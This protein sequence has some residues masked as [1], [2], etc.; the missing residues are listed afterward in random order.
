MLTFAVKPVAVATGVAKVGV[1]PG[2]VAAPVTVHINEEVPTEPPLSVAVTTT[3]EFV[4]FA[5]GVPE[6]KPVAGAMVSPVGSPVAE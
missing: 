3:A 4:T 5:V 1:R 6:I 2:R